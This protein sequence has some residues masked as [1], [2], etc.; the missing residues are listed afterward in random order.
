[1]ILTTN[2]LD[3]HILSYFSQN[4][5]ALAITSK[6]VDDIDLLT[7]LLNDMLRPPLKNNFSAA[8]ARRIDCIVPFVPFDAEE[9]YVIAGM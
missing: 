4:P 9:Q 5:E 1:L 8:L 3:H 6:S 2:V 7:D